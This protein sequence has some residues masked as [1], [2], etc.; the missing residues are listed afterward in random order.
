MTAYNETSKLKEQKKLLILNNAHAAFVH[1]NLAIASC[2]QKEHLIE[3]SKGYALGVC[4]RAKFQLRTH[5][6]LGGVGELFR[7][8]NLFIANIKQALFI[9]AD[10]ICGVLECFYI[11]PI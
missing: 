3:N 2:G 10:A 1:I 8:L 6:R 4:T 7:I 11:Y 9:Q 5:S